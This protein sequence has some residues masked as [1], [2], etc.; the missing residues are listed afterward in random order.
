[1]IDITGATCQFDLSLDYMPPGSTI[2][3]WGWANTGTGVFADVIP[4]VDIP[5]FMPPAVLFDDFVW[6]VPANFCETQGGGDYWITGIINPPP[7]GACLDIFT[8]FFGLEISCP[9]AM[10][11]GGC[12]LYT[13]RCV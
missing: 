9:E 3:G 11:S 6:T 10:L 1:M 4:V 8:S 7:S 5:P 12:L 2:D 13:S